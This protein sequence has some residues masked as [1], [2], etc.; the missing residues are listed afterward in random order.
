MGSEL[1]PLLLSSPP[2]T[3][4]GLVS[5]QEIKSCCFSFSTSRG[6]T[7]FVIEE[8]GSDHLLKSSPVI[9]II[10]YWC[11]SSSQLLHQSTVSHVLNLLSDLLLQIPLCIPH[12]LNYC[13]LLSLPPPSLTLCHCRYLAFADCALVPHQHR[14]QTPQLEGTGDL[15]AP[16]VKDVIKTPIFFLI[17]SFSKKIKRTTKPS[18]FQSINSIYYVQI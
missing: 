10:K 1:Q 11:Y 6:R 4:L 17:L 3:T 2:K 8:N 12:P 15:R 16:V 13:S 14:P 9:L 5:R 7:H 18:F